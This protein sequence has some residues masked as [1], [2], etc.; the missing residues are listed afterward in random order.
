MSQHTC[1]RHQHTWTVGYDP[2]MASY[3]ARR[4]PLYLPRLA[5]LPD[6]EATPQQRRAAAAA[7]TAAHTLAMRQAY[8]SS[9]DTGHDT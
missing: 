1:T 4:Q 9:P 3:Y 6:P 2:A 5:A 8:G 7:F